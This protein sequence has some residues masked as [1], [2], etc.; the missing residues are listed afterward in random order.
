M[1][2]AIVWGVLWLAFAFLG[3]WVIFAIA[4][5][6]GVALAAATERIWVAPLLSVLGWLGAAAWF[7]FAAVQVVL[8]IISIVQIAAAG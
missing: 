6:G 5:F 2:E 8:Q 7:V 4:A 3:A 1:T